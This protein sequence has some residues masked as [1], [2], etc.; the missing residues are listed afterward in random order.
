MRITAI[1]CTR[2]G[3]HDAKS[4]FFFWMH[5]QYIERQYKNTQREVQHD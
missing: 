1:K 4:F 3:N 2:Y 5:F